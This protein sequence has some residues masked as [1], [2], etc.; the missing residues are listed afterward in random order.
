MK[1]TTLILLLTII[2][3]GCEK[4]KENI[5]QTYPLSELS[6][7]IR[8]DSLYTGQKLIEYPSLVSKESP[9]YTKKDLENLDYNTEVRMGDIFF[10]IPDKCEIFKKDS[11]YYIDFPLDLSYDI[12]I[13]FKEVDNK[14]DLMDLSEEIIEKENLKEKLLSKPIRNKSTDLDSAYFISK[15][16]EYTYTHF[17]IKSTNSTIYF[18]IKENKVNVGGKIMA[19][20]LMTA[21]PAGF[22]PYE[23]SKSFDDYLNSLSIYATKEVT[24][25]DVSLNIPENFY[26]NQEDENFKYFLAKDDNKV[27]GEIIMKEDK[28]EGN[29]YDTYSLNSGDTIY[30][31]QIINMGKVNLSKNILEGEVRL[32]SKENSLTGKKF[33]IQRKN[34]YIT[35]IVVG[36][37]A[38]KSLAISMADS[39]KESIEE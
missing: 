5:N 24:L 33:V 19:D 30:P 27:I 3:L 11:S 23:V 29:I 35:I 17:L 4:N 26:L 16:K 28:T 34:S 36:P 7:F 9:S 14:L 21:Y 2:L 1:K 31:T 25:S 13:N 8:D 10:R 18:V 39:I 6:E 22:D 15:D 32:L 38:N 37:L 12:L 20:I